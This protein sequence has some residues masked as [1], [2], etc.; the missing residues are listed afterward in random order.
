VDPLGI[1]GFYR[2]QLHLLWRWSGG[3]HTVAWHGALIFATSVA[4]FGV[5]AWLVPG[6][7]VR[8]APVAVVAALALALVAIVT[9]PVLIAL[10]SGVSVMLVGAGTLVLQA[11]ALLAVARLSAG[12]GIDGTRSAIGGAAIYA[13]THT[14]LAA[15]LS[16]ANDDSFFGTLVRQLAARSPRERVAGP[17][18]VFVQIDG[19]A[20]P[21]LERAIHD[22]LT[23]TL[24]RWL[25]TGNVTLDVWTPLL[26]TQTSASQAG[27]LHGNN[28]GIPG[29]RWFEKEDGRLFV[30][31]HPRDARDIM[32]RISDGDGLLADG[33]SVGNLLS[34]DAR[35]SFLTAATVDDPARELRRSH[36]IDW[37]FVSPYAYLRWLVLSV[38]EIV[39]E[40]VQARLES[41]RGAEP[42]GARA[43]PYPFARAATN[44]VLRHLVASLVIEEMYRGVP[45]IYADLVDYDEI[46]HHAGVD[47]VEARQALRGIDRIVG[48]LE[49]A[50]LDA[51][52]RYRFVVLSD[53]GQTPGPM[54][55]AR[56]KEKLADVIGSLMGEGIE[57]HAAASSE[58]G[59]R[60]FTLH[61]EAF[62]ALGGAL[63][64][65]RP[66]AGGAHGDG[67]PPELVV[68]ASGNLAHV[69]LPRLPGRATR[70]DIDA[71]YPRLIA[72]LVA[73]PGV[74]F[75]MVRTRDGDT[76]VLARG[77]TRTLRG[78]RTLGSDPLAPYGPHAAAGLERLD[79]M[80]NCGDLVVLGR[81][82]PATGEA[83]G[84]EDQIGSHGGLG[85]W[86]E[87]AFILHPAEWPLDG[88][89]VGAT[90]L[91]RRLRAWLRGL[92]AS[93]TAPADRCAT[94]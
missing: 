15:G 73:H 30:S 1:T 93:A 39:K 87:D 43:F 29:F 27:I 94:A 90:E 41:A 92:G 58:H 3:W 31:N 52:R 86:Q 57:T 20:H 53:H 85:G 35:R 47:R 59:G 38:G 24:A 56:F 26:P 76:I 42:R 34:G 9:R 50:A 61:L 91:H 48:L 12:I 14:L 16:I 17:G 18:V 7:A 19:L 89:V 63:R 75:V 51:P 6:I 49:K 77:G 44:V 45:V 80:R 40:V 79:A 62:S 28:D 33:A 82:D 66:R 55:H 36:V 67:D 8:D 2:R 68:A 13:V 88:P 10:L 72:G 83:I 25:A 64:P 23:P 60:L 74:G 11:L 37:F 70:E 81:Y 78:G 69:S 32:R 71:R 46:A 5:T 21:A 22:G 4:A 84:F 54:F 65:L